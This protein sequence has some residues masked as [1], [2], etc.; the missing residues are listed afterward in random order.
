MRST[1]LAALLVIPLLASCMF[2]LDFDELQSG[3]GAEGG[4]P[5]SG[6]AAGAT[7]GGAS[8]A[9]GACTCDDQD[10]CTEDR[11]DPDSPDG[12]VHD[13]RPGLVLD[14]LDATL[15]AEQHFR[16]AMVAGGGYFYLSAF[17]LR[18]GEPEVSIYRAGAT[19]SEVETLLTL[20]D[21]VRG[22]G[23]VVSNAGL[24]IDTS[25]G[26]TLH[27]LVAVEGAAGVV[28]VMHV[29]HRQDQTD[30]QTV[31]LDYQ[32]NPLVFPQLL[33]IGTE[34]YGAWI[35]GDGTVAMTEVG[36]GV[37]GVPGLPDM[38]GSS[39]DPAGTLALIASVDNSPALLYTTPSGVFAD[40]GQSRVQVEEC[41]PADGDYLSSSAIETPVPGLWLANFTKF[42][43]DYLTNGS[44]T[45]VCSAERCASKTERCT[46][47]DANNGARNAAGASVRFDTDPAGVGYSVLALPSVAASEGTASGIEASLTLAGFKLDFSTDDVGNQALGEP[48][49]VSTMATTE[50]LSFAGPDWPALAILATR[51]VGLAWIQPKLDGT[52]SELRVQR[53]RMCTAD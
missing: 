35:Q 37:P 3:N 29:T 33:T 50:E 25:F 8:G 34:R 23:T 15:E 16:V 24:A 2:L 21:P 1:S 42:G 46:A 41:Q 53:Y 5:S 22:D 31:G 44:A 26:I 17:E 36:P 47:E 52:G 12:C 51:Q 39:A 6:G 14:G 32:P 20:S 48:F 9:G 13:P 4:E 27:G 30:V 49:F 43:A 45:L 40:T 19:G 28:R 11:C 18:D 10:P 7:S 38:F